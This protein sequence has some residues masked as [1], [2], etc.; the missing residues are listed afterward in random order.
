MWRGNK[1]VLTRLFVSLSFPGWRI[2]RYAFMHI[3]THCSCSNEPK[4]PDKDKLH[5]ENE[6]IKKTNLQEKNSSKNGEFMPQSFHLCF[7]SS[8]KWLDWFRS[9]VLLIT[10]FIQFLHSYIEQMAVLGSAALETSS[11]HT[12]LFPQ[13]CIW[14]F[15]LTWY[16]HQLAVILLCPHAL[17]QLQLKHA[18]TS[19]VIF[20]DPVLVLHNS[21]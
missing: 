14:T 13:L 12:P 11:F 4:I 8:A 3:C 15:V 9:A 7:V 21:V 20:L 18:M 6:Y 1:R 2:F 17:L 19:Q 10:C 16:T 5:L